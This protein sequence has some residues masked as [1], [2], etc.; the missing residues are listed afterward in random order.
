MDGSLSQETLR[1][2]F[3]GK[4]APVRSR[5]SHRIAL[6][7]VAL[8][9][10]TLPLFYLALAAAAGYLGYL[11]AV[12]NTWILR[13]GV[14]WLYLPIYAGPVVAAFAV[15]FFML[16]PFWARP[17]RHMPPLVLA[18]A[19]A[20][21]LFEFVDLVR[22]AVRAPA[23]REIRVDAAV[24][25]SAAFRREALSL[26]LPA[27]LALTIGVPLLLGLTLRQ[28]AGV[29]AHEFGHFCQGGDMRL[30]YLIRRVNTWLYRTAYER[31]QWDEQLAVHAERSDWRI[32]LV[33][34]LAR[35]M[36][37]LTRKILALFALVGHA[38]SSYTMRQA[39][40][41]AD[42]YE[43]RLAGSA[44]FEA[45]S[46]RVAGLL[47][48]RQ[49]ALAASRA[50]WRDGRL[51]EDL[52]GLGVALT[53]RAP[54]EPLNLTAKA[55]T[56]VTKATIFD[57]HPPTVLRIANANREMSTGLFNLE[58]RASELVPELSALA[59]RATC[60]YY[61]DEEGL[62][63][64]PQQLLPL[65]AFLEQRGSRDAEAE[66]ANRYFGPGFHLLCP[67]G[68]KPPALDGPSNL[69]ESLQA[70]NEARD[71]MQKLMP[72][73]SRESEQSRPASPE[74]L[75]PLRYVVQERL[76]AVLSLLKTPE[77]ISRVKSANTIA[78]ELLRLLALQGRLEGA[79]PTVRTVIGVV[80]QAQQAIET[81]VRDPT[82][83]QAAERFTGLMAMLHGWGRELE[84][85]LQDVPY[86]FEHATGPL[87]VSAY[88]RRELPAA[89]GPAYEYECAKEVVNRIVDLY[90]R[91]LGR[92][93]S[94]AEE[95]EKVASQLREA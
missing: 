27:D 49:A 61:R 77:V 80:A 85:H 69:E 32:G 29:L 55:M 15:V 22:R 37:W 3:E 39:E 4:I 66:A 24:N 90:S 82:N 56:D 62:K 68:A 95:V 21:L 79:E 83:E 7:L 63:F 52:P 23:P 6:L 14:L 64:E 20:P 75:T 18:R 38:V 16:K 2:A 74:Q 87:S 31:D 47:A 33:L 50:S 71:A 59:R 92:M 91:S 72:A 73:P 13:G 76:Q 65:T 1:K 10:V 40:Y 54:V 8:L 28:L 30:S 17:A 57:T 44:E 51:C 93:A 78:D 25:A 12:H 41:E 19:E 9:T 58:G 34:Q 60:A 48:G 5:L 42:R 84:Q 45:T 53:D 88:L 94:Q 81:V 67:V 26:L 35:L 86:P 70:L 36:V 46:L 11:H 43:S 89:K